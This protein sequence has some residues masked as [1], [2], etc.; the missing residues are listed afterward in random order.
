M[1]FYTFAC[2]RSHVVSTTYATNSEEELSFEH[3]KTHYL[4]YYTKDVV[5]SQSIYKCNGHYKSC[6]S[7]QIIYTTGFLRLIWCP[8][9]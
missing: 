8:N 9:I 6:L 5:S 7:L 4:A 2:V 3:I 1:F